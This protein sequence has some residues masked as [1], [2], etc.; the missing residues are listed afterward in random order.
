MHLSEPRFPADANP[1][2]HPVSL[3][4]L[5]R[6]WPMAACALLAFTPSLARADDS[7]ESGNEDEDSRRVPAE[8]A[9]FIEPRSSLM[10]WRQV[11]L[12]RDGRKDYLFI[13][14]RQGAEGEDPLE[15][16]QRPLKIALRGA[17]GRLHLVLSNE[18]LVR[19]HNC[20]GTWPDPF[21]DLS[22]ATGTFTLAHYGGSRWRWSDRW[23][24][25]YDARANTWFLTKA[26]LGSDTE[27]DGHQV[28]TYRRG[29]HFGSVP[30]KGFSQEQFF[31][32]HLRKNVPQPKPVTDP[33]RS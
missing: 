10:V 29:R 9:P 28:R 5:H 14:E 15:D 27:A 33:N 12:N 17:D 22:A 18:E 1:P 8:L 31:A 3:R 23:R 26:E 21:D 30:L 11:D 4:V 2:M 6:A 24:F 20:G 25:D 7:T 16:H 13:L 32:R 19:C